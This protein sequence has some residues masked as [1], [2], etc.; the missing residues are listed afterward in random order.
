MANSPICL[1]GNLTH[2]PQ[3]TRTPSGALVCRLRMA[4]DRRTRG[5]GTNDV[6]EKTD[7]LFI[8]VEAWGDLAYNCRTSLLKGMPVIVS[9]HLVTS[10][11]QDRETGDNRSKIMLRARVVGVDMNRVHVSTRRCRVTPWVTDTGQAYA[12][13][14]PDEQ[15]IDKD[16]WTRPKDE[17]VVPP[18]EE[19]QPAPAESDGGPADELPQVPRSPEPH[20]EPDP[21][22][23]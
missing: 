9:G 15:F 11:W 13:L 1:S 23:A 14:E 2:M 6:W 21:V 8:D 19:D 7:E 3:L 12:A 22:A 20:P 10:T 16:L 5:A 4:A 18:R 17:F